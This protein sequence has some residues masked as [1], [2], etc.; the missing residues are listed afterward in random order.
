MAGLRKASAYSKKR[1]LP[2]TRTSKKK[3]KSYVKTVP[4][5]KIVKFAM[6][7]ERLYA[8]GK[9][10]HVLTLVSVENVQIRHNA[11][12]ACRQYINKKLDEEFNGQY[13]FRIIP[14]SHH[15]Q[16]ENKMITGAGADRMQTGMQLSFG[17]SAGKSAIVKLNGRLFMVAV[18]NVKAISFTRKLYKQIKSKLPG[19]TKV[20]YED[21]RK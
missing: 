16:R 11:L 1:V 2:Y 12:E 17:K 15:I 9:L 14:Y 5:Q 4:Q 20:L 19:K 10:P 18:G 13:F 7:R 21:I 6:G 8:R 3:G